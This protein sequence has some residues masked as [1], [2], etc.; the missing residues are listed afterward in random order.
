ME[1]QPLTRPA[2]MRRLWIGFG[3]VLLLTVMAQFFI[4]VPGSFPLS[5]TFGFGAWYGFGVCIVL[6]LAAR[7]LG[8][9]LMRPQ[10]YYGSTPEEDLHD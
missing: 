4:E 8:W 9:L 10:D 2:T 5:E 6:M 1:S 3:C 7:I